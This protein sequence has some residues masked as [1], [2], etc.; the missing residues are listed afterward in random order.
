MT[1][2]F[3]VTAWNQ[4]GRRSIKLRGPLSPDRIVDLDMSRYSEEEVS[5]IKD[6]TVF[7]AAGLGKFLGRTK[8]AIYQKRRRLGVRKN[9]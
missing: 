8:N 2:Q 3:F 9:Q 6:N 1:K 5:C 7:T 4:D